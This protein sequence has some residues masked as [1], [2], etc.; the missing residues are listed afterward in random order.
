MYPFSHIYN[1]AYAAASEHYAFGPWQIDVDMFE[2][3]EKPVGYIVSA[4]QAFWPG[5]QVLAGQVTEAVQSHYAFM[6]L[7]AIYG[8]IPDAF[9]LATKGTTVHGKAYHLRPE[10]AESTMHLYAA[11]RN[12]MYL[13][14]GRE[15]LERLETVSKVDC[16]FASVKDVATGEL[17][18]RMDSFFT[19]ETLKYLYILFDLGT[20]QQSHDGKHQLRE[21]DAGYANPTPTP[22]P[23][24]YS[25]DHPQP[26]PQLQAPRGSWGEWA[27]PQLVVFSTEGH[28]MWLGARKLRSRDIPRGGIRP[29]V[30][31]TEWYLLHHSHCPSVRKLPFGGASNDRNDQQAISCPVASFMSIA[32]EKVKQARVAFHP[33]ESQPPTSDF[34]LISAI[35]TVS[36][37]A[38]LSVHRLVSALGA[39][40]RGVHVKK[41]HSSE[42]QTQTAMFSMVLSARGA[43]WPFDP[44]TN[45]VLLDAIPSDACSPLRNVRAI[46]RALR[47][48]RNTA[49]HVRE[50]RID[51]G[52]GT[53]SANTG[54]DVSVGVLVNDRGCG[55]AIKAKHIQQ[56]GAQALIL[57]RR[58]TTK[59][60]TKQTKS[61]GKP[62]D[63]LPSNMLVGVIPEQVGRLIREHSHLLFR[64]QSPRDVG[65][66]EQDAN[67]LHW[68][69]QVPN[70]Q[71]RWISHGSRAE[72]VGVGRKTKRTYSP[73]MFGFVQMLYDGVLDSI[74]LLFARLEP[75]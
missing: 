36:V 35:K 72:S 56:T 44:P 15:M 45:L 47:R 39:L 9:D 10:L 73:N 69:L 67:E 11:T 38:K 30:S 12:P 14:F 61:Q 59:V 4:L 25:A 57:V 33:V 43:T 21:S 64:N 60:G 52:A 41:Q 18:D 24:R 74:E 22:D 28:V 6:H 7:W 34:T 8:A 48:T 16:G 23:D 51:S 27:D 50:G 75:Y 65:G 1:S 5:M 46:T 40:R 19:S 32:T 20:K 62:D 3:K 54:H 71:T 68:L 42:P 2:G 17:D 29:K 26:L 66:E 58:R 13:E 55:L 53:A 63:A 31:E 37:R 70:H 49:F